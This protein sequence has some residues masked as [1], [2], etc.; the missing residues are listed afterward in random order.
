MTIHDQ[1]T[2]NFYRWEQRGRGV[3][4]FPAA[5]AL[6]PPFVPFPGHRVQLANERQDTGTRSTFLSRLADKAFRA[7]QPPKAGT[8]A[9][10]EPTVE[11]EAEPMP[12]WFGENEPVIE[13][14]LRL[15]S[16]VAYPEATMAHFLTTLSLMS[17]LVGLEIIG[18]EKEIV[19]QLVCQPDEATVVVAQLQAHC[20]EVK[21]DW[22]RETLLSVWPDNDGLSDHI[23]GSERLVLDFGLYKE[24][25]RPLETGSRID[26]FV[27]LI[28]GMAHLAEGEVAV[29]Q[30]L[31]TPLRAPWADNALAAV[32][33]Q[34]GHPFLDDGA[35]LVKQT[36]AKVSRPLYGVVLRLASKATEEGGLR[37]AWE[38]IHGMAPAL[39]LFSRIGGQSLM[40]LSNADYDHEE[41]CD[42]LLWRRSRRCGMILN[43]DEL[44][45]LAHFPSGSV[46]TEKLR[47]VAEDTTRAAPA[48][49]LHDVTE[50]T[51]ELGMNEHDGLDQRV[52]LT[53][54]QRLQHMHCIGGSGVGKSTMLLAMLLQDVNHGRGFALID[55]HGDLVDAVLSHM[56]D[57]RMGDVVLLDPSDEDHIIPFNILSAHSDYE[58]TLLASDLVSVFR[59]FSTSWGDRMGIIFQNLVLAFLEHPQGGTLAEM[60]KFLIDAEWRTQFLSAVDDSH[61]RFY[62]E[63]TF[64]KL[65]G[66]KSVGPILTRLGALLTPKVIRYM[67]SQRENRLDFSR[68]MDDRRILLIRLPQGQIGKENAHMLGSLVMVKLQQM[69]MSRARIAASERQ[70][71]FLYV[72]ECQNF[73]TPSM[74]EIL[75][76]A[77]KYGLGLI[78]AHQ[79]LHQLASCPEVAAAV[80]SNVA[81]RVVF[82]VSE[83]DGRALKGDFA[84]YEPKDFATLA[85]GHAI[86]RIGRADQ[87]FNLR[88]LRPDDPD[89]NEGVA[90]RNLAIETSRLRYTV[91]RAKVEEEIR[92]QL[93]EQSPSPSPAKAKRAASTRA[94]KEELPPEV[95]TPLAHEEDVSASSLALAPDAPVFTES[96]TVSSISGKGG[97]EHR[98]L[99]S[100]I[101]KSAE[102]LGFR[103][104]IEAQVGDGHASIDVIVRRDSLSI[105][106][107]ISVTTPALHELENLKKCLAGGFS[108]VVMLSEDDAFRTRLRHL[109]ERAFQPEELAKITFS[110]V[111]EFIGYLE[112]IQSEAA[113]A[114]DKRVRGFKV[115]RTFVPMSPAERKA[116]SEKA[117]KL[118]AEEI[119][120]PPPTS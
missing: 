94:P 73:V 41:H 95:S 69:A 53:T 111:D 70:P 113:G 106:C 27:S 4:L 74:A 36:Q 58:K 23:D 42:D 81:T 62:W 43:L 37:R 88:V 103:A 115:K 86:C 72:D 61:V 7:L 6:E 14:S 77:R 10:R 19:L 11:D 85:T 2:A 89:E 20:P 44:V 78:L 75:S 22:S 38:I 102:A 112:S 54:Q 80:M 46:R 24:F 51:L 39:R 5:V 30:C 35:D 13:I 56:P 26:P 9:L 68:I 31:F 63:Q 90:R 64:P 71:F 117:L 98:A 3:E 105:A 82:R 93:S 60:E 65:D 28:G 52:V 87:D 50:H 79:D 120:R 84:H 16:G 12:D 92:K 32:T 83:S 8:L 1:L 47:R 17:S 45:A 21:L 48:S 116:F 55:P 67:M 66:A 104:E 108:R 76:G 59:R 33:K 15:P 34:N 109:A 25:M 107:E 100:R 40:P 118:L 96:E 18:T 97:A 91:P 99:Q 114:G 57:S 101:Q 49:A 110:S 119:R 29:Y